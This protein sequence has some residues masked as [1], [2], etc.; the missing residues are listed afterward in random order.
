MSGGENERIGGY[1]EVTG[2][3]KMILKIFSEKVHTSD[4]FWWNTSLH[5]VAYP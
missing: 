5:P 3:Q 4:A 1:H 2:M